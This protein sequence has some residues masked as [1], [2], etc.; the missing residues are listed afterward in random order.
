MRDKCFLFRIESVWL[1]TELRPGLL[2]KI[3]L[4][5]H[6]GDLQRDTLVD[7]SLV[8]YFSM[9]EKRESI[10]LFTNLEDSFRLRKHY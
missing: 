9:I 3:Q 1:E 10:A 2:G 8:L 5:N 6:A 7:L 4:R